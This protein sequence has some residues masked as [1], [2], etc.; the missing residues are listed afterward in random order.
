[1]TAK[2]LLGSVPPAPENMSKK[3]RQKYGVSLK[4]KRI[5]QS[6]GLDVSGQDPVE[7]DLMWYMSKPPV[8]MRSGSETLNSSQM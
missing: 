7:G 3:E 6:S 5:L 8:R 4:K 1:M 2:I